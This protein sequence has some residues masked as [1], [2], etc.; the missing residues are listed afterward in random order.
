[1]KTDDLSHSFQTPEFLETLANYEEMVRQHCTRYFESNDL[2]LLAEYYVTQQKIKKAEEVISYALTIHP[3]NLEL[4]IYQ[5]NSLIAKGELDEAEQILNQLPDQ[6]DEE[7]IYSRV[8]ICLERG[9][10]Q[11]TDSLLIPLVESEAYDPD[12]LVDIVNIFLDANN[13]T[14]ARK[15]LDI[16]FEH[17]DNSQTLVL[18]TAADFFM[19]FN[20]Y[21]QAIDTYNQLLDIDPYQ[22]DYW[23]NLTQAYLA[24]EQT[25]QAF[26]A[27]DFALTVKEKHSK[28]LELK[29]YCYLQSN[30]PEEAIQY[31]EQALPDSQ[32]PANLYQ[33]LEACYTSLGKDEQSIIYLNKLLDDPEIPDFERAIYYQ[34]L[35]AR[36]LQ[37]SHFDSC[38]ECALKGLE[39][40]DGYAPLYLILGE[41]YLFDNDQHSAE[42]EFAHA[43]AYATDEK[44]LQEQIFGAYFRASYFH[45][46]LK[47]FQQMEEKYPLMVDKYYFCAAYCCYA[48]HDETN[49]MK[50]LVR[51]NTILQQFQDKNERLQLSD[52]TPEVEDFMKMIREAHHG[53]EEGSIHPEDYFDLPER[54][55][56]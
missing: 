8:N 37:L 16:L 31:F 17:A 11:K 7:V 26:N 41:Y 3:D 25:E 14:Y 48:I 34:K 10:E 19:T 49:L 23:L 44:E 28:A 50:Y 24:N 54:P 13:E 42:Q 30:N 55:I 52:M 6:Q 29:G 9:Q 22:L 20:H 39:Y 47:C 45:E 12:M 2:L 46:A 33:I 32:A 35:A 38:L 56:P 51:G 1:M 36:H 15:W 4:Q 21:Q 18:E 5:C 43:E 40:D 27:I 53:I